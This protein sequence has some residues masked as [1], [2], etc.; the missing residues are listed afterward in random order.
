VTAP[1]GAPLPGWFGETISAI[2]EGTDPAIDTA[3]GKLKA[4]RA[5]EMDA[6]RKLAEQING[7]RI[8]SSTLVRDFVTQ[9]DEIQAQVNAV[10]A[11]AVAEPPSIEGGVARVR[12]SIPAAQVWHVLNQEMLIRQRGGQG[13]MGG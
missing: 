7:L 6:M 3:Q 13:A 10:L 4:V 11:G 9:S 1:A 5:A 8:D 2:G 12:V